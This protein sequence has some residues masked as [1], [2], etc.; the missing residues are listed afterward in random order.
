MWK[1]Q[2]EALHLPGAGR[3]RSHVRHG[4]RAADPQDSGTD[5]GGATTLYSFL[6]SSS[7]LGYF[8]TVPS[9]RLIAR[10]TDADVECHLA[11]GCPPARRGLLEGLRPDQRRRFGAERQPQHPADR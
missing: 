10:Q 6:F 4:L 2:P 7:R 3:G 5:Q 1:D 9:F 8:T 11:K